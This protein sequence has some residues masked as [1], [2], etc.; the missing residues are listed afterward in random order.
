MGFRRMVTS[1]DGEGGG[2]RTPNQRVKN[3]L[4]LSIELRPRIYAPQVPRLKGLE[5]VHR[6]HYSVAKGACHPSVT[7]QS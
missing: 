5:G 1:F 2:T 6:C 4:L 7:A 3:P